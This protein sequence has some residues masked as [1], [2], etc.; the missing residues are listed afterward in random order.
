MSLSLAPLI[1]RNLLVLCRS[2]V[3]VRDGCEWVVSFFALLHT[4]NIPST[5]SLFLST[6]NHLSPL[7]SHLCLSIFPLPYL[8]FSLSP[9]TFLCTPFLQPPPSQI[10]LLH[11]GKSTTDF[12]FLSIHSPPPL[13]NVLFLLKYIISFQIDLLHFI[14]ITD[15]DHKS[16]VSKSNT[17]VG[18][19][20]RELV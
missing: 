4:T 13:W 7:L 14:S 16:L 8:R 12:P 11:S 18:D 6:A 5:L 2:I 17:S 9:S 10:L 19:L 20:V 1:S 3:L 15:H